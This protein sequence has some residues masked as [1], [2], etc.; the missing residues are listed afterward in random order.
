[1]LQAQF[2]KSR[3]DDLTTAVIALQNGDK[4]QMNFIADAIKSDL[5][6]L[7]MNYA[8][9][10]L[11]HEIDPDDMVQQT[12]IAVWKNAE[13]FDPAKANGRTWIMA[14]ARNQIHDAARNKKKRKGKVVSFTNFGEISGDE[15]T[16]DDGKNDCATRPGILLRD[17]FLCLSKKSADTLRQDMREVPYDCIAASLGIPLG[18]VK[19]RL[20]A[21]KQKLK[22]ALTEN[23]D[24]FGPD[25]RDW[26][27]DHAA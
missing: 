4:S 7:L 10:M 20:N 2:Q 16:G 18:T 1:M 27:L 8:G 6:P 22:R 5:R 25:V 23:P 21:A 15:F 26:I 17:A 19:S 9:T 24:A 13:K 12:M 3:T 11:T 14:I